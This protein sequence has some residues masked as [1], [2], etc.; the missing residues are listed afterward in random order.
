M[1]ERVKDFFN[2]DNVR[3]P[4]PM[5]DAWKRIFNGR[6]AH[7]KLEFE[8][9]ALVCRSLITARSPSKAMMRDQSKREVHLPPTLPNWQEVSIR[10]PEWTVFFFEISKDNLSEMDCLMMQHMVQAL[11]SKQKGETVKYV[12]KLVENE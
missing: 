11:A 12:E 5:R 4:M 6:V 8:K 7:V 3:A 2:K 10:V 1:I 9:S